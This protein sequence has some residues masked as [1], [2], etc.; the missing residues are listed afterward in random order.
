MIVDRNGISRKTAH[1]IDVFGE[2]EFVP[3]CEFELGSFSAVVNITVF[4]LDVANGSHRMNAQSALLELEFRANFLVGS[5]PEYSRSNIVFIV[6]T[7]TQ[8]RQQML[9]NP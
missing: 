5:G 9:Q 8:S 2:S 6:G 7:C 4:G 1:C 3:H